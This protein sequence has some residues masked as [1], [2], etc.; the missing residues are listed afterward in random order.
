MRLGVFLPGMFTRI[1]A[2]VLRRSIALREEVE[3][4]LKNCKKRANMDLFVEID[5]PHK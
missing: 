1:V 5:L 2:V 4:R 3:V